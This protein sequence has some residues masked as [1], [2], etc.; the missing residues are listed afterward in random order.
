MTS[1]KEKIDI[2]MKY[3]KNFSLKFLN[4]IVNNKK[5]YRYNILAI[6]ILI[7]V[8]IYGI[9]YFIIYKNI[10]GDSET[11]KVPSWLN[12]YTAHIIHSPELDTESILSSTHIFTCETN[13]T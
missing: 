13:I 11:E 8:T 7:F 5:Y 4:F 1:I 10:W 3:L 6:L 2:I 9:L 12:L